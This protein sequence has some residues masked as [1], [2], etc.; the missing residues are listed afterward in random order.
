[1]ETE[2][3]L[4][5]NDWGIIAP[6]YAFYV[7]IYTAGYF[8][9]TEALNYAGAA[10]ILWA[11][12]LSGSLRWDR[13]PSLPLVVF[14]LIWPLFGIVFGHADF[15]FVYWFKQAFLL[16]LFLGIR[17]LRLCPLSDTRFRRWF[18]IPLFMILFISLFTR[19]HDLDNRHSGV[20]VNANNYSLVAFGLLLLFNEKRDSAKL[21]YSLHGFIVLILM[22]ASTV[23]ALA[24]Y[25]AA[26]AYQFRRWLGRPRVLLAALALL[27]LAA[28]LYNMTGLG[29]WLGTTNLAQRVS[30]QW[31]SL[32]SNSNDALSGSLDYGSL[33]KQNGEGS[34]SGLWRIAHWSNALRV[35]GASDWTTL[36][37]GMGIG[38]FTDQF[39]NM[40]HNDYLRLL[41][42]QGIGG[43]LA[44]GALVFGLLRRLPPEKKFAAVAFMVFCFSEN[45]IDNILF[46]SLWV[47]YLSTA[48]E[49]GYEKDPEKIPAVDQGP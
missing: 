20:F 24:G 16:L 19:A 4:P 47:M 30:G 6:A 40:A 49:S 41:V 18:I 44:M 34:T 13:E 29:N 28:A 8:L 7:A 1:M 10:V 48:A 45:N 42:E 11:I 27:L 3:N 26:W 37:F 36:L 23:G 35:F 46:M 9:N 43:A 39:G 31:T 2:W 15:Y 5:R 12:F 33:V 21:R 38:S 25:A 14:L 22:V 17:G 32:S